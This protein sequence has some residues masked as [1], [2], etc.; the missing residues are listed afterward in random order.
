MKFIST[1]HSSAAV[2]YSEALVN[3]LAPDGGLYIPETWPKF[4]STDFETLSSMH[5]VALKIL[6]PF[7]SGDRLEGQLRSILESTLHFPIPL[8]SLKGDT[9]VLELFHGPTNAFK[10][11]GARFLSECVARLRD[12]G[13]PL[14]TVMVA[15]SGDTGGAV[16]GAFFGRPGIEVLILFPK[17][18][19][20]A[21]QEKQLTCWGGNVKTFAVHGTF[22]DCQR[23]VK[24]AL[25]DSNW[26]KD[27]T[28]ISAN[29]I[30]IGRLLP[31]MIYYAH[32]SLTYWRS[33][34]HQP[35]F[36]IPSGNLGNAVASMWAKKMGLPIDHIVLATN[37]NPSVTE[38]F[39][40]G[41]WK[42][43]ETQVTL[44]N[45]MDVGNPSNMERV[46]ALYPDFKQLKKDISAVSVSDDEIRSTIADGK[47]NWNEIWCPHTATAVRARER[48]GGHHWI[49]VATAHPAKFESIVE[50]LIGEEVPVPAE[51]QTLLDRPSHIQE[52]EPTLQA[53]KDRLSS[54]A[55]EKKSLPPRSRK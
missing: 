15:T 7:F 8:K 24:T 23:L 1:R 18:R 33:K 55:P 22:D 35:S 2:G 14:A 41:E 16:A 40:T 45:A 42:S 5:D 50:P 27:K 54:I 17:G 51:L 13:A 36:I 44:A 47:S 10:D 4:E 30:N 43:F 28:L 49:L 6:R 38:Y 46:L 37:S 12:P 53:L 34:G 32:S 52:I 3:G 26:R 39:K 20:S 9:A 25:H 48:L 19:I 29:S 31:Q 21:R 11:V